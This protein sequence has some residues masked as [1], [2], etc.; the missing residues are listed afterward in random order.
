MAAVQSSAAREYSEA[1]YPDLEHTGPDTLAG[2]YLRL[3]WQPIYRAEDVPVGRAL[4][5]RA[6]GEDLTLYRGESG[7][8]H[9]VA[10]RCAHRG[11]QLSTG[12]VEGET[13]RCFY[14]GW[15]YDGSGQCVEQPAEPEPFCQ[16]IRI[17]SYPVQDYLG[18]VFAY[19]G[20]G[21]P[22]PLPRFYGGE[23]ATLREVETFVWPF[24][25]WQA[26]DNK[27]DYAHLPFVHGRKPT[28]G[29]RDTDMSTLRLPA[30]ASFEETEWGYTSRLTYRN[31][32]VHAEHILMPNGYLHKSRPGN[33]R[34]EDPPQGWHDT[35]RWTVPVDDEHHRDISVYLG[36]ATE[37]EARSYRERRREILEELDALPALDLVQAV[38]NGQMHVAELQAYSMHGASLED[39]VARWGQGTIA[40]RSPEHLGRSD[41]SL[42]LYRSLWKREMRALAEGRPLKHWFC[43]PDLL[44]EY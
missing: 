29:F 24:N 3:F 32:A 17:R 34:P 18:V 22:P 21:D 23:Q 28:T 10:F 5:V 25:Y 31:G 2:R 33:P 40:D 1:D 38:L 35:L 9:A 6:L 13:I 39:G 37:E 36:E 12:W 42:L 30:A 19:L 4:P 44:A 16:R 15:A 20:E 8:I 26:L 11:T 27:Q 7:Q 43:P 41:G 14:H